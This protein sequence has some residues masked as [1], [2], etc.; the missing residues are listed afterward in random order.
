MTIRWRPAEPVDV[1]A[2]ETKHS[3]A[4]Q[5]LRDAIPG[6]PIRVHP[7]SESA[8]AA[9]A[10]AIVLAESAELEP[11]LRRSLAL[12]DLASL[13]PEA[14]L[15]AAG[16]ADRAAVTLIGHDHPGVIYAVQE[17]VDRRLTLSPA[18]V[19]VPAFVTRH[20]PA[21]PYRLFWT[22]DHSTNWSLDQLGLQEVGACNVYSKPATGFVE[23]YRR[24]IEFMSQHRLNGLVIYGFLRDGHGGIETAKEIARYG[25]ERGVR[26]LPGVGINAYGGIYWE[27]NHRYNLGTWLRENRDLR[28]HLDKELFFPM[29]HFG[30]LACPSKEANLLYHREAIRWLCE[31]F[32]IGGINFESGDYSICQCPDCKSRRTDEGHWSITD[33]AELYPPLFDEVRRAKPDAWLI[34]EAYFDN[35][36]DLE[37]LAPLAE[38][39]HDTI[40]QYCINRPYWPRVQSE[41]TA[42]HVS[43]L[44]Q[45]RNVL[46][47]HMGSQWNRERYQPVA[48]TFA[49]LTRLAI[50]T[51]LQGVDLFGE[52]SAFST[53]NEINYLAY[54]TFANDRE[55][56]WDAFVAGV[57][58]PRLGGADAAN[59]YLRLLDT[60]PDTAALA[61]AVGRAREIATPLTDTGQHRRWTWLTNRLYQTW[62]M[63]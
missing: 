52:V 55:T 37:T 20:Q 41:L 28:A 13:G 9:S 60:P 26:I 8:L 24:L 44:P 18:G 2:D 42:A 50:E 25:K 57:L 63:C 10:P 30:E 19:E 48:R 47:T 34:A 32:D 36:L 23:D 33:I 1:L 17:F 21:L 43:R 4:V 29:N 27:G 53:V 39:P 54:A 56:S 38:L 46:R 12:D 15:A 35:L 58:G 6:H 31:E 16:A 22:W 62:A 7:V 11:S 59:E 3:Y 5:L 61:Q 49:D 14:Y 45:R 40:C 51:G